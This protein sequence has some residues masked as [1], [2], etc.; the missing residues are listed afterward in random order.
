MMKAIDGWLQISA[1]IVLKQLVEAINAFGNPGRLAW[2]GLWLAGRCK[3]TGLHTFTG[4][5]DA[6]LPHAIFLDTAEGLLPHLLNAKQAV[7]VDIVNRVFTSQ[8]SHLQTLTGTALHAAA[9]MGRVS[10][11]ELL[12]QHGANPN[13]HAIWSPAQDQGK[14]TPTRA[15]DLVMQAVKSRGLSYADAKRVLGLLGDAA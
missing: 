9:W 3:V 5:Q 7:D 12:L 11:V 8:V 4:R 1:P 6:A 10:D 2:C 15:A 14:T 13:A